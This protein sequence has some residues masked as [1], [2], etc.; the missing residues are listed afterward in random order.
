MTNTTCSVDEC[1]GLVKRKGY[2]YGHYMKQW[3]YGTP[4]PTFPPKW[5]DLRGRRFG[6]LVVV[7][8]AADVWLCDCDCGAS[9]TARSGDLNRGTVATCGNRAVHLRR[10]D[11]GYGA[12]HE[13]VRADRGDA[14]THSCIDCGTRAAQWSYDHTDPAEQLD[15]L[16]GRH[17][18]IAYSVH[19]SHYEPR[20]VP[21]HKRFDLGRRDSAPHEEAS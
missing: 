19:P 18:P 17:Q 5:E 14:S 2:C 4:T 21:C 16:Q 12:A 3:R 13:R 8:R 6:S 9:T 7:E 20:C 11:I 1:A 15:V 10:D